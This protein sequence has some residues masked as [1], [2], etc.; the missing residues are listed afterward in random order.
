MALS[1]YNS[2][3]SQGRIPSVSDACSENLTAAALCRSFAISVIISSR[4]SS[5]PFTRRMHLSMSHQMNNPIVTTALISA[6][7]TATDF[8]TLFSILNASLKSEVSNA[9]IVVKKI[10]SGIRHHSPCGLKRRESRCIL[11]STNRK[12]H[13]SIFSTSGGAICVIPG[14]GLMVLSAMI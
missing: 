3:A 12:C 7:R 5:G 4:I 9:C 1:G 6:D 11:S 13:L 14:I 2:A 8:Q 10:P